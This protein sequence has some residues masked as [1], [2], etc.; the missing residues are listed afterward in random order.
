MKRFAKGVIMLCL[1]IVST[2]PV[3]LATANEEAKLT[4]IEVFSRLPQFYSVAL[5][6][7][8]NRIAMERNSGSEDLAALMTLD[9]ET[10][11]VFYLLRA[12]NKK[13]K[14]NWYRWANDEDLL[15]SAKYE[16][17]EAGTKYFKT[18]LYVMKYNEQGGDPE[19]VIDWRHIKRYQENSKRA[20]QF[21]DEIIDML[22]DDPDH[23]LMAIDI[24]RPLEP[25]VFKVNVKT[26]KISRLEKGKKRIRDWMT[27][28]Q[29]NLRIGI[30]LNYETG[31]RDIYLLNEEDEY[32]KLFSYNVSDDKPIS[33]AG[34]A[35]DPNILYFK[36]YLGDYRALYK[37]D[38][39]TR[40][41]TLVYADD[42]YDVDGSLIYSP[43]TKDAI[44][45]RHA[46]AKG[47]RYYWEPRYEALQE[48][49]N[50]VLKDRKNYLV[51]FSQN[52]D[53]YLLYSESDTHPGRYYVGNQ[54][55]G[56]LKFLFDQYPD[57]VPESLSDHT[58]VD[59]T[60]RDKATIEGYLTLPKHG[61]APYPTVIFP[62]GGP[63][64]RDYA[65][66]DYWT[67]YFNSR[68]YAVMRPNFRGSTGYGYSFSE[69]QMQSWGMA[70]Q[71]D[72]A[73]ATQW[74]ID[75]GYT[76]KSKVCIVGASYG[77]FAALAATVKS[78]EMY[79]CAVSF[80]GV[81]DLDRL[82]FRARAFVNKKFVKEQIGEDR[83]DRERR[84]PI[85]FVENIKTP[86]L[87]IHG[88]EDRVVHVEQS[89]NMAEELEDHDKVF[90]YVELPFG[91]HHLA[92]QS[93]RM[94]TFEAMDT[95]LSKYL[96]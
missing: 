76:D 83:D 82:V 73:D 93:N 20:P 64:G 13:V 17:S 78:P 5:S 1:C 80:A 43:V 75:Q 35:A 18:R 39:T 24:A 2:A 96:Q 94:K 54:R 66:F 87:L 27:D 63:G 49:L 81:S 42:E 69:A 34:F 25:S 85:N 50:N 60:M 52:E 23:I 92:I 62:H 70:M 57:I 37:M 55:E 61:E 65:G 44:G 15:V 3:S 41:E 14:I 59:I 91:N 48:N 38:L 74:M 53:V 7:S 77:G 8:G 19:Q 30:T 67:A 58:R 71:D 51:K 56:T 11:K 21:Q 84:S 86:I 10:G 36:R 26:R 68:G 88:E 33:I 16:I 6:P 12:D 89:R 31:D 9:I 40:E 45:V 79:T 32:E 72:I 46:N 95:F 22:P 90:E 29:G 4:P 47:G 28:R